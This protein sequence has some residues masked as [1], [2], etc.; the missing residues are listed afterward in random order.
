MSYNESKTVLRI[1]IPSL[2]GKSYHEAYKYFSSILGEAD[3]ID[4][5]DDV[6]EYFSYYEKNHKYI[7]VREYSYGRDAVNDRWGVDLLLAYGN[8]YRDSIGRAN[9]SLQE[10]NKLANDLGEKF[11]VDPKTARLVSYTWYNGG[12][13]PVNFE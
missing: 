12:D 7:P 4:D 9:H 13:E 2:R 6:I 11:N 5:W 10:L 8:D 3:D 1:E